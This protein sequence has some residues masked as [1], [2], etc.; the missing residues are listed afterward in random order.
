MRQIYCGNINLTEL[1]DKYWVLVLYNV[2]KIFMYEQTV[3]YIYITDHL[4]PIYIYMGDIVGV[5]C[6]T[7]LKI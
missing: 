3:I 1:Y 5:G 2:L 6:Q 4:S 7:L